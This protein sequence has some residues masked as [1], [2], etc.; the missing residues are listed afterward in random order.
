MKADSLYTRPLADEICDRIAGGQTLVDICKDPHIVV[1]PNT[2]RS[3]HHRNVDG[4]SER[5][6]F[7][8]Q[9]FGEYYA[10]KINEVCLMLELGMIKPSAARVMIDAYKWIASKLTPKIFGDKTQLVGDGGGPIAVDKVE[11]IIVDPKI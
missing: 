9:E 3:W 8:R 4:F 5:Y 10:A 6:V 2:I 1:R 11:R 7:A